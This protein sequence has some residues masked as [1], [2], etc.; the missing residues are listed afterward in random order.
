MSRLSLPP[1]RGFISVKRSQ[2]IQDTGGSQKARAVVAC[3]M[4][5]VGT[6]GFR[7]TSKPIKTARPKICEIT[8]RGE[9]VFSTRIEKI[10]THPSAEDDERPYGKKNSKRATPHFL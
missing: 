7:Q 2:E 10:A 6:S 8:E 1:A 5:N 4:R 9:R 3:G